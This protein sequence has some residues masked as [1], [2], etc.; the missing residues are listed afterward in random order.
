MAVRTILGNEARLLRADPALLAG[1]AL[2]GAVFAYALLNGA[3]WVAR[4]NTT[5]ED[6]R[7]AEVER[8]AALEA[9]LAEIAAGAEPASRFRDPRSPTVLGGNRG[10]RTAVLPPGPLAALSVGQ[11]DLRPYYYDVSIYTNEQTF[12]QNGEVENPLNLMVGRFD[13]AF[14]LTYLLPLLVIALGYS[15]LSAEREQGTLAL[16]LSQPVTVR[17]VVGARLL[18]RA[19]IVIG[20]GVGA[21]LVGAAVSGGFGTPG[22]VAL[23]CGA[24]V[25]YTLFWF[26]LSAWVNTLGRSSSWN[27]TAL[28]GAWLALVVVVPAMVNIAAGLLHPLPSRVEMISTAREASNE[29]VNSRS[30]LLARYLEDHPE[31]AGAVVADVAGTAALSWAATVEVDRR[32]AEVAA[33]YDE[34]L[35][36]QHSIVRR[37]RILSPALLAQELLNDAAGSGDVRFADFDGQVRAFAEAWRAYF[38]PSILS[39]GVMTSEAVAGRPVF[40][41][42]PEPFTGVVGR[43]TGPLLLLLLS[44]ML[45]TVPAIVG[46]GA[47][48]GAA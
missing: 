17:A 39:G 42:R 15:V 30:E 38:V 41:Y 35:A 5:L 21:S 33:R 19:S 20:L 32:V 10:A 12:L 46:L 2:F 7:A 8:S 11:S 28:V 23:W 22:R 16:T 45:V 4:Q 3:A 37:Y 14:V 34:Q 27:A 6:V 1:L 24:V 18:F 13:L 43:A 31:M 29:A 9:E 25:L 36:Q 47:V 44:A 26:G 48:R 40:T